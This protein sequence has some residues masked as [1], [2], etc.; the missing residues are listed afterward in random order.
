MRKYRLLLAIITAIASLPHAYAGLGDQ[1][2]RVL[3][4]HSKALLTHQGLYNQISYST[5]DGVNLHEYSDLVQHRVFALSWSGSR[6][7]P[8][9]AVVDSD[10]LKTALA[11]RHRVDHHA[12]TLQVGNTVIE[13]RVYLRSYFGRAWQPQNLPAGVTPGSLP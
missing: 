9:S 7:Y 1:E 10:A 5:G 2:S 3:T 6:P 13:S 12:M 4:V 8:L 11:Q